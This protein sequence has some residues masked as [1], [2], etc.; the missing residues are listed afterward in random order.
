MAVIRFSLLAGAFLFAAGPAVAGPAEDGRG[1]LAAGRGKDAAP[2]LQ[3]AVE[4]DPGDPDLRADLGRAL[5]WSGRYDEAE[6]SYQVVLSSMPGHREALLGLIR[7]YGY[8]GDF[9]AGIAAAERGLALH[10]GDR[11]IGAER[12]RLRGHQRAS[13]CS[14]KKRFTLHC[15]YGHE[16]YSFTGPGNGAS[17]SLRDR[18]FH[19]WDAGV[20][21]S[22]AHR[23]GL[24]DLDLGVSASRKVP[25]LGGW[26]GFSVGG[27][28]RHVLL[29]VF[30]ASVEGGRP[31]VAGF[32]VETSLGFRRYD[33]AKVF[34]L[35][36]S[37]TWEG[38]GLA[39]TGGYGLSSTYYDS[40]LKSGGLSSF[41]ARA[42]W[43]RSCP[44]IPW[45]SYARTREGFEA[46]SILGAR[47]FS[48]DHYTAGA[49]VHLP[50]G[51]ALDGYGGREVRAANGLSVTRFGLGASFSWGTLK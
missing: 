45:V 14:L 51:L 44:V 30:R 20:A 23:F 33:H 22:Y 13:R 3:A 29:P 47:S 50:R 11:E 34:S 28:T 41:R 7:L 37:L 43:M 48:A 32:G 27:A 18:R 15:G 42:A 10:P 8:R 5:S 35:S 49:T 24:D 26:A 39:L 4:A 25:S 19:G 17:V 21:A 6:R 36:P 12:A 16:D 46:G 31:L 40:G 9:S 38:Y 2:L 1:A